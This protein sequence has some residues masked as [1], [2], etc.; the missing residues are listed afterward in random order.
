M[1]NILISADIHIHDYRSHNLFNDSQFR[2]N[3]FDKLADRFIQISKERDCDTLIIAGD[4]IHVASPPPFVVNAA[5]NFLQKCALHFDKVYLTNGQHEYDSRSKMSS[6]NT[7]L[8]L[9][10][11][12]HSSY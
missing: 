2:L 4:F 6:H 8:T 3:Q 7:L 1:K 10:N 11:L 9:T 5:M 12:I